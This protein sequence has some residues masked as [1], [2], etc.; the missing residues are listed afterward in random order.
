MLSAIVHQWKIPLIEL[1]VVAHKIKRYY[2]KDKLNESNMD[3]FFNTIM[4]QIIYM[5]DTIDGF[6]EF[7]KPSNKPVKFDIHKGITEIE[8]ILDASM[9]YN[10]IIIEYKNELDSEYV[11]YGY[12]NEFK[13]VL[14]NI[15][16][17][18]KDSIT[19]Y[20]QVSKIAKIKILLYR[21]SDKIYIT[22][23]DNGKG[24]CEDIIPHVFE[25]FF[26]TKKDG[27]GDGF[28]LYMAKLIIENK[29]NGSIKA[30]NTK[31]GAKIEIQLPL[32][33][34]KD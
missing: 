28:G 20:R 2:E 27:N 34:E 6:R 33:I 22:V 26:S 25:A 10:N 15:I 7:I 21:K 30:S 19:Q 11:L 32:S 16:N 29:M 12:P 5:G 14:L 3:D 9:K 18:S 24:F 1:S 13:Q 17:N 8:T 23:R 31:D 4:K